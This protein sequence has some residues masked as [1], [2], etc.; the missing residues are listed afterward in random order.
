MAK[1]SWNPFVILTDSEKIQ[2]LSLNVSKPSFFC[3][4]FAK[5]YLK[6]IKMLAFFILCK[7]QHKVIKNLYLARLLNL[8]SCD[9]TC[10][11]SGFCFIQK[12]YVMIFWGEKFLTVSPLSQITSKELKQ[13][14]SLI[15]KWVISEM[16]LRFF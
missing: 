10:E 13:I 14:K 15:I 9:K 3:V 8:F 16:Y 6:Y 12:Y 4:E 5:Y 1:L 7:T 2:N 11:S